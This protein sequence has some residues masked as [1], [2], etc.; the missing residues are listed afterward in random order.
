MLEEIVAWDKSV[1]LAVNAWSCP[2]GDAFWLFM[3]SRS[4][5]I[6]LYVAMAAL[7]IWKL[8]WKRGLVM[9]AATILCITCVDQLCNLIK[10][11]TARLRPCCD[12]QMLERGV[13]VLD[14][15]HPDYIYGFFSGHA[16]NAMAFSFC[17][18]LAFRTWKKEYPE[19]TKIY[20][21]GSVILLLWALLVGF[22]RVFVAK[23]FLGDVLVGFAVGA[24]LAWA[25]ISL[26]QFVIKK[27]HL[28]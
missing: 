10:A 28:A 12:P 18:V 13:R 19:V 3:T 17:M 9:I 8:G 14:P 26:A 24:L 27:Y 25:W 2:A 11:W 22:S 5:W 21:T 7:L 4:V 16:A 15:P 1:T 23:H 6:P 20:R